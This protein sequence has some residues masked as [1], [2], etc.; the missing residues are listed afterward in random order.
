MANTLVSANVLNLANKLSPARAEASKQKAQQSELIISL[1]RDLQ[2]SLEIDDILTLFINE[3][4]TILSVDGL[5]Y[6]QDALGVKFST[7]N[8]GK[9]HVTYDL[10]AG[11]D[12]LGVMVFSQNKRFN[13]EDLKTLEN[14]MPSLLYPL[15]NALKYQSALKLARTD[16]L[17]GCGNRNSLEVNLEREINIARRD[18]IP[19]SVLIFDFDHFKILND[20]YGHVCGDHVLKQAI[21]EV[22]KITRKTDM[23]FR[24]GGEE[25]VLLLHKTDLTKAA[26]VAE[27]VRGI[28]EEM[29]IRYEASKVDVT[30]SLGVGE[31]DEFD[32]VTSIIE[33]VDKA[34]Y[35]AKKQGRN[36]VCLSAGK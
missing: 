25:F 18:E 10:N 30:I 32:N 23:L 2:S 6:S 8:K 28:I 29:D 15:R 4:R 11:D 20:T 35:N 34:L 9:H 26:Y 27:K 12:A 13:E 1:M 16:V 22:Q 21:R 19:F 24:Y 17:T 7:S 5:S 33:R 36:Q 3:I 31:L 14:I